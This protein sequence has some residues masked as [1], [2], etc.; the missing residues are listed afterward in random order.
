RP[1]PFLTYFILCAIPLLLLAGLNYWNGVSTV[2]STLSTIVQNDLNSFNSAVNDVLE[3]RRQEIAGLAIGGVVQNILLK[4]E[5]NEIDPATNYEQMMDARMRLKS[6]GDYSH[7]F[8]TM[9]VFG[10]DRKP[11]CFRLSGGEWT[12]TDV[13]SVELPQP[14]QRVWTATGT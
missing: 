12:F 4:K 8:L 1:K 11:F 3:K 2:N 10:N 9:A 7:S 14:D 5:K 6:A 13:N